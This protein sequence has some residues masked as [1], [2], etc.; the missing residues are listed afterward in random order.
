MAARSAA[1]RSL[2]GARRAS[3]AAIWSAVRSLSAGA[4][5]FFMSSLCI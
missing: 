3:F 4:V 2:A 1:R 5:K